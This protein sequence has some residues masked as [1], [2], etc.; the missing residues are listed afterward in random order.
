[1]K[2]NVEKC[3]MC[4]LQMDDDCAFMMIKGENKALVCCCERLQKKSVKKE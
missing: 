4:G 2:E 3:P 1:M